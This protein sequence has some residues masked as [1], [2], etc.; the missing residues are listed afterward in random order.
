[1]TSGDETLVDELAPNALRLPDAFQVVLRVLPRDAPPQHAMKENKCRNPHVRR[2][3]NV[4]GLISQRLHNIDET[5]EIR[6]F[7]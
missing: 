4:H 2:T 1:M 7:R 6:W 3:V 5:F